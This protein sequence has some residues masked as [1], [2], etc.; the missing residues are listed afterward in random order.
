M[1]DRRDPV[2]LR[3]PTAL[4]LADGD[5]RNVTELVEQGGV[6]APS[7]RPCSVDTTGVGH[8]R[9]NG[10]PIVSTCEWMM[11]NSADLDQA[12]ARV[13]FRYET[14]SPRYPRRPQAMRDGRH[15]LAIDLGVAR[16]E[17]GD[18]M[19][20]SCRPSTSAATIRSVPAYR[21]GGIGS[22]G[23]ERT[24]MRRGSSRPGARSPA[25]R[26]TLV[27]PAQT[28]YRTAG[29]V[30]CFRPRW[31][32]AEGQGGDPI[33]PIFRRPVVTR[34]LTD[35]LFRFRLVA[36]LRRGEG[37]E[38]GEGGGGRKEGEGGGGGE[39]RGG[40]GRGEGEGGGEGGVRGRGEGGGGGGEEREGG[41]EGGK[42]GEKGG[43]REGGGGRGGGEGGGGGR[44]G[45]SGRCGCRRRPSARRRSRP[46]S[47]DA[48][49]GS[50]PRATSSGSRVTSSA[51]PTR[52]PVGRW[53]L[54]RSR[55]RGS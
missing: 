19:P 28:W 16:R 37:E 42:G 14:R 10:R 49:R 52:S 26:C 12:F 8:H 55:M 6:A 23:G 2:G 34:Y 9:A 21:A 40:R 20:T 27:P 53:C 13:R 24:P 7:K 45:R 47:R 5:Q 43:R 41:R 32:E 29:P 36:D 35:R 11:S 44:R 31:A 50:P 39:K 30:R 51:G 22:M 48:N 3:G 1:R 15:E 17:Q 4:A 38:G 54:R 46:S 18:P 25:M 33:E